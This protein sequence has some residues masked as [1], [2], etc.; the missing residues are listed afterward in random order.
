MRR[1]RLSHFLFM[2]KIIMPDYKK[3]YFSL[4]NDVSD[5]I[6]ELEKIQRDSEERYLS[7]CEDEVEETQKRIPFTPH[8]FSHTGES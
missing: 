3:L 8:T 4:F 2:E 7:S 5:V 6:K 1:L